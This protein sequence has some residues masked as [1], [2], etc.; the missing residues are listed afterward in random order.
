MEYVMAEYFDD[1][2]ASTSI[3]EARSL[4]SNRLVQLAESVVD[5]GLLTR[6]NK[7]ICAMSDSDGSL[8]AIPQS[9]AWNP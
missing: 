3:P 2:F 6:A 7:D 4:R 1:T 5:N 8:G 9:H